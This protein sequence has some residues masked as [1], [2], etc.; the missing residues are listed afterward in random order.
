MNRTSHFVAVLAALALAV[1]ISP[2]TQADLSN[3]QI[4]VK[5][6]IGKVVLGKSVFVPVTS[7]KSDINAALDLFSDSKKICSVTPANKGWNVN[8]LKVG[9]CKLQAYMPGMK[10]KFPSATKYINVPVVAK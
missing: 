7:I 9:T 3:P 4:I 8:G 5:S 10:G 1:G 6:A 2:A